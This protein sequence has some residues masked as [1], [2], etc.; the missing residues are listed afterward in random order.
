MQHQN[1]WPSFISAPKHHPDPTPMY[2][3]PK[4][5][6]VFNC[7]PKYYAPSI[8]RQ[9]IWPFST[10]CQACQGSAH[11][12]H[13]GNGHYKNVW[14]ATYHSDSYI[15][16][17]TIHRDGDIIEITPDPWHHKQNFK[18]SCLSYVLLGGCL[19]IFLAQWR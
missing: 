17:V 9:S 10:V 7:A 4:Y 11:F 1:I 8:V 12:N 13:T 15:E 18:S 3:A 5:L 2:F 16:M 14:G 6:T 19:F